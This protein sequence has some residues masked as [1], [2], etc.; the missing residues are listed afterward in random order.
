VLSRAVFNRALTM[1]CQSHTTRRPRKK[2]HADAGDPSGE[3]SVSSQMRSRR[4]RRRW[5]RGRLAHRRR[6]PR[7]STPEQVGS[8]PP[9]ARSSKSAR[10]CSRPAA[11]SSVARIRIRRNSRITQNAGRPGL[12]TRGDRMTRRRGE[13]FSWMASQI[14]TLVPED[15]S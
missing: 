9:A 1:I 13:L 12:K 14:M 7:H 2:P 10:V 5:A 11:H 3:I 4:E 8:T 15:Y 6:E